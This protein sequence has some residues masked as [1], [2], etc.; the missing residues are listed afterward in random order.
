MAI[1]FWILVFLSPFILYAIYLILDE[2]RDPLAGYHEK[3]RSQHL[4]VALIDDSRGRIA[5]GKFKGIRVRDLHIAW[6]SALSVILI[7]LGTP[8]SIVITI[9]ITGY[10]I[11]IW[12]GR[13]AGRNSAKSVVRQD[14][15]FPAIVELLA[16]LIAAGES[17][18]SA[19]VHVAERAHG[20]LGDSL[21]VVSQVLHN[22]GGLIHSLEL[23]A[24]ESQSGNLK[25]FCDSLIVAVERG[26]PLVNVLQN[27]VTEARSL[28]SYRLIKAAGR[29]EIALMIPIV[30]LILPISILFALWPSYITLGASLHG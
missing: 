1:R 7:A 28:E 12:K 20:S 11:F 3:F 29:A 25:R 17:P 10:S 23:A 9:A 18:S 30:F 27:Q 13:Q 2:G 24:A 8:V 19:L 5:K 26:A 6:A 4:G 15:E 22:G 14:A 21:R 16:I